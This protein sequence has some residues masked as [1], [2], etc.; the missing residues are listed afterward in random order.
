MTNN[1]STYGSC[2]VKEITISVFVYSLCKH[3]QKQITAQTKKK[4]KIRVGA[5]STHFRVFFRILGFFNSTILYIS[6]I[7]LFF[8]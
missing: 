7:K 1:N 6:L 4:Q 8:Q 5:W 3:L 2:Q